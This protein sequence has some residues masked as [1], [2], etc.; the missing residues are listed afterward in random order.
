MDHFP[1]D[2]DELADF[3][4]RLVREPSPSGSEGQVAKIVAD[5]MGRLGLRVQIDDMGNVVGTLDAGPGPRVLLDSHM[6]TVGVT[7]PESWTHDP[8]GQI[9]SGRLYGRGAMDMKGP[10][11]AAVHGIAALRGH[12]GRGSVMV[13]ATIAEE[14]VEGA[15]L[16][17][18]ARQHL[19]DFVIICEATGL[20]LA[21]GQRGRAEIIVEVRG[22]STHSSRPELGVN[23]VQ[24][25][26]D[27]IEALRE[28][29]VRKDEE[30]G[31]GIL[32]LTDISSRPFP[33][34][35]VVPNQCIATF[36]RRTLPGESAES[37]LLEIEEVVTRAL[38]GTGASGEVSIAEDCFKS[39]AGFEVR[40][41]NFAP[42]W[43][44]QADS[45][46]VRGSSAG[47]SSAGIEPFTTHYAF[48]TNG[49]ATAGLMGIPTVG[50]GPGDESIAHRADEYVDLADLVSAARGYAGIAHRLTNSA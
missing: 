15:A 31:A 20:K 17:Y 9:A 4:L 42:A 38:E 24:A 13:T 11:A 19:P 30:L 22:A 12:L 50:F 40:A 32:V 16:G 35:S 45:V 1:I 3:A 43:K 6:D 8:S 41:A 23:A 36:D 26:V 5:E 48:C 44:S 28:T 14:M 21:T 2:V 33:A 25:M 46:I 7:D 47:L 29:P 34:L 49:S 39:Y 37:I 10:L 27:V 18:V